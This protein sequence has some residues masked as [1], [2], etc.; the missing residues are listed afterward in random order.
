MV[1]NNKPKD[2]YRE[3]KPA[4]LRKKRMK[5]F[6]SYNQRAKHNCKHN[7]KP[8]NNHVVR[9]FHFLLLLERELLV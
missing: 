8:G 5:A 7:A 6:N 2:E 4:V 9:D 1:A 3:I